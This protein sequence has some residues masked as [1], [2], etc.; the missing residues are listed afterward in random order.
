MAKKKAVKSVEKQYPASP[1]NPHVSGADPT[2]RDL[3]ADE[4]F[5]TL[6][7]RLDNL[8]VEFDGARKLAD[9]ADSLP[10]EAFRSAVERL[11]STARLARRLLMR[12]E[13]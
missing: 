7:D 11:E 6:L 3:S 10:V 1:E 12:F 8:G 5:G 4:V 9:D 13:Q 2:Y